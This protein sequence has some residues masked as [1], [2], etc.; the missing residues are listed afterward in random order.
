[1]GKVVLFVLRICCLMMKASCKLLR[2]DGVHVPGGKHHVDFY[3]TYLNILKPGFMSIRKIDE[4]E[5]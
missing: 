4:N 3:P 2:S 5:V 1:M